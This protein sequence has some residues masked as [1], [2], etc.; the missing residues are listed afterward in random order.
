[1]E[2]G[3]FDSMHC[4]ICGSELLEADME[5]EVEGEKV[6]YN[7]LYCAACEDVQAT[8]I[9]D[10]NEEQ[11]NRKYRRNH[12]LITPD[13]IRDIREALEET[14]EELSRILGFPDTYWTLWEGGAMPTRAQSNLI[15]LLRRRKNYEF[16]RALY[17]GTR[18]KE[19]AKRKLPDIEDDVDVI[20]M[21]TE[22]SISDDTNPF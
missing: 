22:D 8:A 13:S 12:G 14:P 6:Y 2:F 3:K 1:M 17:R 21:Y 15:R 10:Y 16:L 5:G 19:K 18:V 7:G 11:A 20:M 9:R 4:P